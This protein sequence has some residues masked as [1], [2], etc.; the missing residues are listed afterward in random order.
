M[1][2]NALMAQVTQCNTVI[3]ILSSADLDTR[4]YAHIIFELENNS[5]SAEMF[6]QQSADALLAA[7]RL[8]LHYRETEFTDRRLLADAHAAL[9]ELRCKIMILVDLYWK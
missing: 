6:G 5:S 2:R 9:C 7:V 8:L 4:E 1:E 3:R